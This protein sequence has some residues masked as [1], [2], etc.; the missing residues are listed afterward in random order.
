MFRLRTICILAFFSFLTGCADQAPNSERA[1][2]SFGQRQ[3]EQLL[4]DRPD[5]KDAIPDSHYVASWVAESLNGDRFGSRVYWVA[6]SPRSGAPAECYPPNQGVP[7][8]VRLTAG[9]ELTP[10]D[11]WASVVFE[12]HNLLGSDK[13]TAAT[14]QAYRGELNGEEYAIECVKLEFQA[15]EMTAEFF[16]KHPLPKSEHGRDV[17]YAEVTGLKGSFDDYRAVFEAAGSPV[18]N[19]DFFKKY[20]DEDILPF[21]ETDGKPASDGSEASSAT[22]AE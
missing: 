18:G 8:M 17:F 13:L 16:E 15:L 21:I 11:K 20:Y 9:T 5:M 10:I 22:L 12:L 4:A 3:L 1:K 7:A 19:Y 6:D 2:L 14:K